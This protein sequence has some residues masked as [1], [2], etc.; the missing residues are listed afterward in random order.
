MPVRLIVVA[1]RV[2]VLA[3][4]VVLSLKRS[5]SDPPLPLTVTGPRIGSSD[6]V[7]KNPGSPPKLYASLKPL[8]FS[9][10]D[11]VAGVEMMNSALFSATSEFHTIDS[12]AV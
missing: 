1:V 8:P 5:K 4:A 10:S 11:M 7:P 2:Y 12:N 6:T 9:V 3:T